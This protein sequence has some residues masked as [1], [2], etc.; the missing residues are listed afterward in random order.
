MDSAEAADELIRQMQDVAGPKRPGRPKG[1]KN[2]PKPEVVRQLPAGHC[3]D[4]YRGDP[5]TIA[6]RFFTV[7]DYVQQSIQKRLADYEKD[8]HAEV[9]RDDI[10][11]LEKLANSFHR[12]LMGLQKAGDLAEEMAKRMSPEQLL[13]AALKKIEGQDI[14]TLN[15][16][17]KRLR[18]YRASLAPVDAVDQAQLGENRTAVAA[19]AALEAE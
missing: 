2:K 5:T 10:E 14:A 11:Q 13:D 19:I 7:I 4:A 12:T 18:L 17:I 16:A 8:P 6:A 1:A 3:F 15:A 9:R